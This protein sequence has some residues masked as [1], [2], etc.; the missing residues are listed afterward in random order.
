V[1]RCG[2]RTERGV[3]RSLTVTRW[4]QAFHCLF[5][6]IIQHTDILGSIHI[7]SDV[8]DLCVVT[9]RDVECPCC[10]LPRRDGRNSICCFCTMCWLFSERRDGRPSL[11]I[12]SGS[13]FVDWLPRHAVEVLVALIAIVISNLP[14]V[15]VISPWA[16]LKPIRSKTGFFRITLYV[17]GPKI[18]PS[19]SLWRSGQ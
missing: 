16:L 10:S 12:L 11:G 14:A 4:S 15:I 18:L 17:G 13:V 6:Y 3:R 19:S 5:F 7:S 8:A 2:Y 1:E 9:T